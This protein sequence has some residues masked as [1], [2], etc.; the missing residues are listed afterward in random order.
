MKKEYRDLL[1]EILEDSLERIEELSGFAGIKFQGETVNRINVGLHIANYGDT[2][3]CPGL[4]TY[5]QML[6][7]C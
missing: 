3:K 7:D 5:K 6:E 4:E 1:V 2:N